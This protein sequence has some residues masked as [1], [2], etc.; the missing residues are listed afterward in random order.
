M[1]IIKS[2]LNYKKIA[3]KYDV[4]TKDYTGDEKDIPST[5]KAL[6]KRLKAIDKDEEEAV[7]KL[8]EDKKEIALTDMTREE[9]IRLLNII[10]ENGISLKE[11]SGGVKVYYEIAKSSFLEGLYK[12]L[13]L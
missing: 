11:G 10:K 7:A 1:I 6:E 9:Q 13:K 3:E 5:I 2:Q 12:G 8:R 4:D